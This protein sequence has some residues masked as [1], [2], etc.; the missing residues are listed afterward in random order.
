MR[1]I[2]YTRPSCSQT[3]SDLENFLGGFF[4]GPQAYS[5]TQA[6]GFDSREDKES[7][8]LRFEVPGLKREDLKLNVVDQV[9]TVKGQKKSWKDESAE[10]TSV[11]RRISLPDQVD[12][13]KIEAKVED[14]ILYVTL[15]KREE[16][17]PKEIEI[18]V[19]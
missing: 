8:Q 4:A 17:K 9:L 19:K 16:V 5:Q 13:E 1:L 11:E 14:G 10:S 18:N 7:Y 2:R 6:L 12:P 3:T 15:P